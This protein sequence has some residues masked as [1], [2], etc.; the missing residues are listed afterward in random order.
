MRAKGQAALEYLMT[1]GWAL[2]VIII[3]VAALF[4]LGILSPATY[5]GSTCRGFGKIGYSDH[6]FDASDFNITLYNGT[7][8]DILSGNA[9][10]YVDCD[11]DGTY[12]INKATTASW[13]GST[14]YT[15]NID[16]SGN[17]DCNG[18]SWSTGDTY[19]MEVKITYTP[20][21]KF[22]KTETARCTG[23]VG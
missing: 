16:A 20:R 22:T 23:V 4:A 9:T 8:A 3:V 2:V 11:N 10:V 6:A 7:G 12:E 17:A 15:F 19:N 1:Y 21:G 5:Q 18:S 13:R 14:S